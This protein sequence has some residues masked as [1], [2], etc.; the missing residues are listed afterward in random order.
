MPGD[1]TGGSEVHGL[2][3]RAALPVDRHPDHVLGPAGRQR[4]VAGDVDRLLAGLGHAA[5]DDVVHQGGVEVVAR[6]Q[7][8]QDVRRQVDRMDTG[9]TAVPPADRC[10]DGVDD[11]RVPPGHAP[12]AHR[13][14]P[15]DDGE[16]EHHDR[17]RSRRPGPACAAAAGHRRSTARTRNRLS[18]HRCAPASRCSA[19]RNPYAEV[20][21]Q[22]HHD[23]RGVPAQPP[24]DDQVGPQQAEHR[25]GG[26]QRGL[27]RGWRTRRTA[28]CRPAP[29]PGTSAMKRT[30]AQRRLELRAEHVQARTCSAHV[31]QVLRAGTRTSATGSTHRPRP[32]RSG[33]TGRRQRRRREPPAERRPV[34]AEDEG[35]RR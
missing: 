10:A 19:T 17:R 33:R 11:D 29:T 23:R 15:H 3:R 35:D 14:P 16:H 25:A 12:A 30:P 24:A 26:A 22:Q 32:R 5:P 1:H 4:G 13:G 31:H 7:G 6:D 2:L 27:A 9:Q 20:D 8:V 34:T 18:G 28:R 21:G